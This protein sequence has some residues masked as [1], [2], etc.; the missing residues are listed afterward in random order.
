MN[1]EEIIEHF[2]GLIDEEALDLLERGRETEIFEVDRL[3]ADLIGRNI[4]VK[5]KI[6]KINGRRKIREHEVATAFLGN[7]KLS[8]WDGAIDLLE[9]I[10]EGFIIVIINGMLRKRDENL[11]LVVN[12]WSEIDILSEKSESYFFPLDRLPINER[13]N[14]VGMAIEKPSIRSFLKNNNEV[15]VVGSVFLSDGT[16]TVRLVA[17]DSAVKGLKDVDIY[18]KIQVYDCRVKKNMM[19]ELHCDSL[20]R[21]LLLPEKSEET[22]N[23][24]RSNV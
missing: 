3:N 21:I 12:R 20:S 2:G 15:G 11:E 24:A 1:R 5:G 10:K 18:D 13:V 23:R 7:L 8:F 22:D 9:K 17:W 14:V 16:N 19:I 4:N 6:T